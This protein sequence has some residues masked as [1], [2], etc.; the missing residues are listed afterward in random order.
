[1]SPGS[2][3]TEPIERFGQKTDNL[4]Q[5]LDFYRE[6]TLTKTVGTPGGLSRELYLCDEELFVTG[7]VLQAEGGYIL[8]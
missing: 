1:V 3:H 2:V 5:I 8:A 6:H 7:T 4:E